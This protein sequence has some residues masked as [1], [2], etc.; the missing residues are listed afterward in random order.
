MSRR[1]DSV[2]CF[3]PGHCAKLQAIIERSSKDKR[4]SEKPWLVVVDDDTIMR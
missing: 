1:V 2:L 3:I 4:F